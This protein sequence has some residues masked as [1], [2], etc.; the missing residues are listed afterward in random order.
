MA[1]TDAMISITS[2]YLMYATVQSTKIYKMDISV[3]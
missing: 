1:R 3:E 2:S